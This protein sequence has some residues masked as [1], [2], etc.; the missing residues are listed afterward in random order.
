[1]APFSPTTDLVSDELARSLQRTAQL[2]MA[3]MIPA[4]IAHGQCRTSSELPTGGWGTDLESKGVADAKCSISVGY[5]VAA[6]K[7]PSGHGDALECEAASSFRSRNERY[8]PRA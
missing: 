5:G 4:N 6:L 8:P 1:M 2:H 7:Q 3:A